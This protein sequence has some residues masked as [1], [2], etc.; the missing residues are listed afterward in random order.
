MKIACIIP[1]RYESTRLPGKPLR[2][3]HGKTLIRRV[4]ERAVQA[5]VP[6]AVLVATDHP[7][8]EKEVR[9]F[10]GQPVMTSP[11]CPTGTDRLAEVIRQYPEYDIIVNVQGDEPLIDPDV[12]DRLARCLAEHSGLDMATAATPLKEEE[13]ED[14]SSVKVVVNRKGE[15]LYFSRSL[16]PYPRHNFASPPL[17]HVGIYAY[18]RD[19]LAA[20]AEMEQT[21]LEKTES[22][23]QL[24]ALEMGY[25]IGVILEETADIGIDTE[26]DL[27]RAEAYFERME[28][29]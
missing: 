4:Y 17:K 6:D 7:D 25:K 5:S 21:P 20:Y 11:D 15:A 14:A 1:A 16:I 24:R 12:I 27:K 2:L 19:F 29:E 26:E 3:I 18:R 23:E 8:I 9:S 13:Y 10:G 28:Q 22:L